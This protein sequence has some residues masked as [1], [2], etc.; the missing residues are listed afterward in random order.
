V[1]WAGK[2]AAG[3]GGRLHIVHVSAAEAVDEA[4]RWPGVTVE[5]CPHYLGLT[6][7]DVEVIGPEAWCAPPIRDAGNRQ[8]LWD[9]V[10]SGA[11]DCIASDHSPCP[12]AA[13]QGPEPWLGITG[14]ETGL[15][16]LLD[17]GRL[18]LDDLVR[19]TTAA[20]E[21][22]HLPGKGRLTPGFDGDLALVDPQATWTVEP[23][24]LHN[25]H[26][27]SPWTGRTLRGRVVRTLLRGR[28]VFDIDDGPRSPGGGRVLRVR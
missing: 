19:L 2:L 8:R 13:K 21:L 4:R 17:D 23:A 1:A 22:L 16:V 28:T 10:L 26:R 7:D 5:T 12:T 27:R 11:V 9:R 14:V 3:T 6:A 15:S 25:R 18:P 20:A 24:A